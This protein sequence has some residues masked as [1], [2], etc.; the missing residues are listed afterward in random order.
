LLSLS[1]YTLHN[2]L[3]LTT[4]THE[5]PAPPAQIPAAPHTTA[6]LSSNGPLPTVP[7]FKTSR[8]PY[9]VVS[10]PTTHLDSPDTPQLGSSYSESE[11]HF[12]GAWIG[13]AP[14]TPAPPKGDSSSD[15]LTQQVKNTTPTEKARE[16]LPAALAQY[17]RTSFLLETQGA[18]GT[19]L[20]YVFPSLSSH[21]REY[22]CRPHFL[23][24]RPRH[25][26]PL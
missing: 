26:H 11:P 17:L 21:Y 19:V 4:P 22:D 7:A 13:T 23:R 1:L 20:I 2:H 6:T 10:A 18:L 12:P 3:R 25:Q 24:S 9:S 16:V 8:S 5:H 15:Y 14:G